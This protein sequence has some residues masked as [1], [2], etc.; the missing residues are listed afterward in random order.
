MLYTSILPEVGSVRW[1]LDYTI[2]E[3][4]VH[5]VA[6]PLFFVELLDTSNE[7]I[8][9]SFTADRNQLT[10]LVYTLKDAIHQGKMVQKA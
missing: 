1:R 2:R 4:N 7:R 6:E 5:R 3:T 8:L 9:L 10:D